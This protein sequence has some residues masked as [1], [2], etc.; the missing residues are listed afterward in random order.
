MVR[1]GA[2][3][4][5]I[6]TCPSAVGSAALW[7]WAVR[8]GGERTVGGACCTVP[9]E[10]RPGPHHQVAGRIGIWYT[11]ERRMVHTYKHG[12]GV[13]DGRGDGGRGSVADDVFDGLKNLGRG[14]EVVLLVREG[15]RR[16]GV[17]GGAGRKKHAV[18][19]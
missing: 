19:L 3:L 13:V 9:K 1:I 4:C 7:H 15:E 16:V 10:G 18:L 12:K 14:G 8:N 2:L 6:D 11:A 17:R 5:V